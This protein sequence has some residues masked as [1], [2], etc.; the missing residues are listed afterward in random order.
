[1]SSLQSDFHVVAGCKGLPHINATCRWPN[2]FGYPE[3]AVRKRA[4]AVQ[5][6]IDG[7]PCDFE[8]RPERE[9]CARR[10]VLTAANR[11]AERDL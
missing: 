5:L 1:M 6:C 2:A 10:S 8:G 4:H 3:P 7:I 9:R 11:L